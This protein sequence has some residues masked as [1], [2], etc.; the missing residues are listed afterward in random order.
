MSNTNLHP[1]GNV[2]ELSL[3]QI[4]LNFGE[5]KIVVK[6]AYIVSGT[7]MKTTGEFISCDSTFIRDGMLKFSLNKAD[8]VGGTAISSIPM[9]GRLKVEIKK[10]MNRREETRSILIDVIPG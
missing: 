4:P 9:L 10:V 7:L 1:M 6:N 3:F 5:I 8:V 2:G